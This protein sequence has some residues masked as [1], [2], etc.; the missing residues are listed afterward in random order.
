MIC[1]KF[2]IWLTVITSQPVTAMYWCSSWLLRQHW[3]RKEFPVPV[4]DSVPFRV[5]IPWQG[6]GCLSL[7]SHMNLENLLGSLINWC[8]DLSWYMYQYCGCEILCSFGIK[9]TD[10]SIWCARGYIMSTHRIYDMHIYLSLSKVSIF[11]PAQGQDKHRVGYSPLLH[12]W[13]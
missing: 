4:G 10:D 7:D 11:Y 6:G 1:E 13:I 12:T 5:L 2:S 9:K 3:L 8:Y